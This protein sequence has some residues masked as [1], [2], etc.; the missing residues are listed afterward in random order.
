MRARSSRRRAGVGRGELGLFGVPVNP[1]THVASGP[2]ELSPGSPRV[3]PSGGGSGEWSRLAARPVKPHEGDGRPPG[4]CPAGYLA[5]LLWRQ[6]DVDAEHHDICPAPAAPPRSELLRCVSLLDPHDSPRPSYGSAEAPRTPALSPSSSAKQAF[7]GVW[8]G[9]G[10]KWEA[11]LLLGVPGA[12]SSLFPS[13]LPSGH[14][15]GESRAEPWSCQL[16][17]EGHADKRGCQP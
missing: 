11:C 15:F 4:T 6:Q 14:S 7:E 9:S 17:P 3:G 2:R 5:Q 13:T 1:W 16:P 10:Q 12:P 8:A